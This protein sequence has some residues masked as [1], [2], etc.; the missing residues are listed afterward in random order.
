MFVDASSVDWAKLGR[1]DTDQVCVGSDGASYFG[2]FR[3]YKH[4]TP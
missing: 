1:S 2:G 4:F 3:C